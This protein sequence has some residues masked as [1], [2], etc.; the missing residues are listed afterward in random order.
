MGYVGMLCVGID[1]IETARIKDAVSRHP[2]FYRRI[3]APSEQAIYEG[4]ADSTEFL[5]GRFA[6]KEAIMKCIGTGLRGF[7]WHDMEV[8]PD[9]QGCPQVVFSSGING[10]LEK[11]NIAYIKISISHSRDYAAAVAVGEEKTAEGGK[12]EAG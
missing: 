7:S 11:R 9:Q 6:A 12:D 3:L 5:A 2:A 8:L 4:R 10:I 1:I